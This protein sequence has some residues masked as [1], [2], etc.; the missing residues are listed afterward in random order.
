MHF[1]SLARV[2]QPPK[3][4]QPRIECDQASLP[5]RPE[6]RRSTIEARVQIVML[7]E[8]P[9]R[10]MMD[11]LDDELDRRASLKRP[12]SELQ[13]GWTVNPIGLKPRFDILVA[14]DRNE[15]LTPLPHSLRK[16]GTPDLR[17]CTI[18]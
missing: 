18:H 16:R 15:T 5:K 1:A 8:H 4:G 7:V 3:E 14:R 6:A 17:H 9:P 2:L 13:L 11:A 12:P 10:G